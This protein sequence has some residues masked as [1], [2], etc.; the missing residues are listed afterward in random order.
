[1]LADD[2]IAA[3]LIAE[4]D[5]ELAARRL[6]VGANEQGGKDNITAVVARIECG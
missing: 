5:P 1:M 3:I 2:Q 6:V 4:P